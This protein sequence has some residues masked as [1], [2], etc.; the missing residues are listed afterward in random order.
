VQSTIALTVQVFNE[1]TL[2]W[3]LL[4][5]DR[6]SAGLCISFGFH[7]EFPSIEP[8]LIAWRGIVLMTSPR[9]I[10]LSEAGPSPLA[11]FPLGEI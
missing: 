6:Y 3:C 8:G 9:F 10:S 1:Q 7:L 11:P 4:V 2:L 5:H